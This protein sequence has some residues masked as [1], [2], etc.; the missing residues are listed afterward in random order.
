[1]RLW[2]LNRGGMIM[3]IIFVLRIYHYPN[4]QCDGSKTTTL[5]LEE[6]APIYKLVALF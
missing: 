3:T 1:M 6:M 2:R 5:R 4:R